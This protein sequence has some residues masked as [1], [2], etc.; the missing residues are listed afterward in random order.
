M[1]PLY[2]FT[3]S[4]WIH[5]IVT[6]TN[7]NLASLCPH[8][9]CKF[10]KQWHQFT[11]RMCCIICRRYVNSSNSDRPWQFTDRNLIPVFS[12]GM[13]IH[14]MVTE[15]TWKL[16]I[17]RCCIVVYRRYVKASN[18]NAKY[19]IMETY[20]LVFLGCMWIHQIVENP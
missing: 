9:V 13:W 16:L 10:I 4:T 12:V 11:N 7:V 1:L 17:G 20:S 15:I 8:E 18:N 2:V 3:G 19:S 6:S 5:Q 14:E